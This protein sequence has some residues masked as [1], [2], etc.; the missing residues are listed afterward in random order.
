MRIILLTCIA[1]VLAAV[2]VL[3][4]VT[5]V[6]C[7]TEPSSQMLRAPVYDWHDTFTGEVEVRYWHDEAHEVGVWVVTQSTG[8]SIAVLPDSMYEV[9]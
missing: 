5:L 3:V 9:D 7:A 1:L 8:T 6:G 2:L 4:V